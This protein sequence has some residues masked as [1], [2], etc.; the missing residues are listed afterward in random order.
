VCIGLGAATVVLDAPRTLER[1][2]SGGDWRCAPG[3]LELL[4]DGYAQ[5]VIV[6]QTS[7]LSTV[8]EEALFKLLSSASP[9]AAIIR[10]KSGPRASA[11]LLAA[12][13][14]PP[15]SATSV[16]TT[17]CTPFYSAPMVAARALSR[18]PPPEPASAP[19]NPAFEGVRVLTLPPPPPLA[20]EKLIAR[21]SSLLALPAA[22][23]PQKNP[24]TPQIMLL[25]GTLTVVPPGG[26]GAVA[27]AIDA[28]PAVVRPPT[29]T[30]SAQA[31]P[32]VCVCRGMSAAD[33]GKALLDCR[34]LPS[35]KPLFTVDSLPPEHT[36][37]LRESL[38]DNAPLP[39]GVFY[40]GRSYVSMDGDKSEHH[41]D[42][43]AG[44][45]KLLTEL[46]AGVQGENEEADAAAARAEAEA[47]QYLRQL[48]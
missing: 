22:P 8:A 1:W 17:S 42:I 20:L 24:H 23:P 2:S 4:D 29:P 16:L 44:L 27:M 5:A 12:L 33:V 40:D 13:V 9:R 32:L 10:A 41:P 45:S 48:A 35:R 47:S 26:G 31:P 25:H 19:A 36:K 3:V 46:N 38:R 43:D 6:S 39:E 15:R 11:T 30:A 37:A 18:Q 28:S 34:P 21:L 7:E 14:L